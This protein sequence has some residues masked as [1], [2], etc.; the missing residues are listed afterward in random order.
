MSNNNKKKKIIKQKTMEHKN[1]MFLLLLFVCFFWKHSVPILLRVHSILI[2]PEKYRLYEKKSKI[3][4]NKRILKKTK[5]CL[6]RGDWTWTSNLS[7]PKQMRYQITLH[8]DI[9]WLLIIINISCIIVPRP[10]LILKLYW[11]QI[12]HC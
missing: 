7:F 5:L 1:C 11:L 8:P 9:K 6:D 10:F 2:H 12:F 4:I 3:T